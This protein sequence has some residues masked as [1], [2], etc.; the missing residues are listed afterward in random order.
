LIFSLL[1][2]KL[3]LIPL[4]LLP[5][6]ILPPARFTRKGMYAS[7]LGTTVV[8][9]LIEVAGW[10]IIASARSESLMAND[11]NPLAQ[12]RYIAG[13]P[14]AFPQTVIKDLL[15]NGWTYFQ[16]WLN[17][18]GYYY[19]TPPLI[20]SLFFLLGLA[21]VLLMNSTHE[22]IG[23]KFRIVFIFVFVMGYLAT[24]GAEYATFTPVGS[25][26]IFGVQGR[27]FIPL[28]LLLF[29]TLSSLLWTR[30]TTISSPK[31][32]MIF[33]STALFL[34]IA[35][36]FLSFYVPCGSTFYQTELCYRPLFRNFPSEA[37]A[38]QPVSNEL[39]F[40]QEVQVECDGLTEVRL[41]TIPSAAGDKG[42]TRFILRDPISG[43][44]LLD[45]SVVNAQIIVEDWYPLRFQ[46]DWH[47][48]G[49]QY[50]LEI[51]SANIPGSNGLKF[52]LI[53]QSGFNPGKF[54][55]NGIPAPDDLVLQ[56]GCT[57]GLRKIWSTGQGLKP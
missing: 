20:V 31:W 46:P 47:S 11:A 35:G 9:F 40:A 33:L 52:L 27:Y 53:P 8:L 42:S 49:K 5:F 25:D 56:Y 54:Y 13:H 2:A 6:L 21:S 44:T 19:W 30:K 26:Q 50:V 57:T 34:N 18:Y 4:I 55:E 7:L 41:L 23:R 43:Q 28:A 10:Y 29:L 22:R 24:V 14:L 37:Y 12:L 16:G 39:A 3:N 36:L 38:S 32:I 15:A 45:T 51:S 17:G 48:A 1:L